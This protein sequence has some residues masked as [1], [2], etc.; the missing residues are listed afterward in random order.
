MAFAE[1]NTLKE[2]VDETTL[3]KDDITNN[4]DTLK[5]NLENKGIE[6]TEVSKLPDLI[7]KVN[8][9]EVERHTNIPKWLD[10]G[11]HDIA[12][13]FIKEKPSFLG[14][15]YSCSAYNRK[16]FF[17]TGN[18]TYYYDIDAKVY[19]QLSDSLNQPPVSVAI[20]VDDAIFLC[21]G[22]ITGSYYK[23]C[24]KYDIETD[25]WSY[26][27]DIPS[28]VSRGCGVAKED[29]SGFYLSYSTLYSYDIE[30]DTWTS[31]GSGFSSGYRNMIINNNKLI[32][33]PY[34]TGSSIVS[35]IIY[36]L[37]TNVK[38]TISFESKDYVRQ[39]AFGF[40]C[41]NKIYIQGGQSG[42]NAEWY[43]GYYDISTQKFYYCPNINKFGAGDVLYIDGIPC[44]IGGNGGRISDVE[45]MAFA[46]Y[47]IS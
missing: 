15:D 19:I 40:S 33:A 37:A 38:E 3:I 25:T 34:S 10:I 45:P 39:G 44:I 6:T 23:H 13:P 1:N 2:L 20:T 29:L 7:D 4:R 11:L 28:G 22:T 36:D 18:K 24:Q 14:S 27:K 21:G 32:A 17:F 35:A 46:Y 43:A 9:I 16:L 47:F 41:K 26:K 5:S 8:G 12:I 30:T 42:G 31:A